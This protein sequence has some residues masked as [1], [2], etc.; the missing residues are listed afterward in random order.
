[1]LKKRILRCNTCGERRDTKC[2]RP[3]CRINTEKGN[4]MGCGCG[5]NRKEE[6]KG[7]EKEFNPNGEGK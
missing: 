3:K 4:D 6:E 1:M 7:K 2:D 5:I